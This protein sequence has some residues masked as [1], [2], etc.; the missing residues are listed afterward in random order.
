MLAASLPTKFPVPFANNCVPTNTNPIPQASQIGVVTGAASLVD[1]FPPVTFI[2]V[3]AG[4]TPP[5]GR[6]FNG[7][8]NQITA[9]TQFADCAGGLPL[10]DATFSSAI[11]G[12]PKGA[13]IAAISGATAGSPQGGEHLWLSTIDNNTTNPDT[14][15]NT[16][17]WTPVPAVIDT[18]VTFTVHGGGAQFAD[19]NVAMEYLSKFTITQNGQVTLQ[20]AGASSGI[21]TQYTYSTLVLFDHPNNDRIQ[22]FGATMLAPI[23]SS[24]SSYA[25]SGYANRAADSAA[26]LTMLRT[27]F[28]T[29]LHFTSGSTGIEI[30]GIML[31]AIDAILM[32]G[33]SSNSGSAGLYVT[34]ASQQSSSMQASNSS[35]GMAFS[36]F[37]YGVLAVNGGCLQIDSTPLWVSFGNLTYG[38]YCLTR[39]ILAHNG[40]VYSFGN[41]SSGIV[42]QL[43]S[44]FYG[45]FTSSIAN[46]GHGISMENARITLI[47][48][49]H[50]YKNSGWGL[51]A[52]DG[53]SFSCPPVDFG[54]GGNA[55]VAGPII[56]VNMSV[57]SISG[58]SADTAG[59]SP[60]VNVVGNGNS[61]IT[62]L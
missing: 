31:L 36:G 19:L 59:S 24:E 39:S 62:T 44:H 60:A 16:A 12:Y 34:C 29:E 28:A 4:G 6:D 11:G 26:N 22:L 10:F 53:S 49:G 27:K 25:I 48:G 30:T 57:A 55:N 54:G 33:D 38:I 52:I 20:L 43:N 56:V 18:H 9:W 42:V 13:L 5:W 41:G 7:L 45:G 40:T 1:G 61:I 15:F 50:L 2:P 37:G 47:F 8:F 35:N 46:N 14:T 3:G 32:T 51:L 58:G 23:P 17:N 21:A